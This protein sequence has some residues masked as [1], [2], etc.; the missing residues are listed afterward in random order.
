MALTHKITCPECRSEFLRTNKQVNAVIKR[1]GLW[2]CQA[3]VNSARNKART[4]AI[5]ATRIHNKK[6]Y[7]VQKTNTGWR[8]QHLVVMEAHIGR[9]LKKD[10]AV[11]HINFIKTDN[12]INNLLLMKHGEH[13]RLH[14]LE[15]A[16][17]GIRK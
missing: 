12:D 15:R 2:R 17:N 6:G 4:S 8:F 11:H 7:V 1:S 16:K 3:C 5:G 10:E 14:N 13:T 9:P